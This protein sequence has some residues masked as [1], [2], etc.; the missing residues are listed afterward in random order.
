[1]E[2]CLLWLNV[3]FFNLGG[4]GGENLIPIWARGY[5]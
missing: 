5:K 3:F 1:M 4:S 2:A